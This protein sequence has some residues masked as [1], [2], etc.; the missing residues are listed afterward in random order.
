MKKITFLLFIAFALSFTWQ[1]NAQ[2]E[3]GFE[4]DPPAG[5]T[6]MQTETDDPGFVQ[7]SARANSGTYSF[8]HNDDNLAAEST[9]W[10]IS[11]ALT[12]SIGDVLSFYHNH[13]YDTYGVEN[14]I[15]ISTASADPIT[16]PGDFTLLYDLL[17]NLSED[18]WTEY[19]QSLDAYDGMTV[20]FAF[21]Y[22]GDFEDELYIDD[23]FAGTPPSC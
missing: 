4:T 3:E 16:N 18:T 19:S 10:M 8:Y 6:F 12:V 13:N 1:S 11:P 22:T 9:S 20:Y 5:W 7:T 15:W 14:G 21:K 23:F 2:I 17:A